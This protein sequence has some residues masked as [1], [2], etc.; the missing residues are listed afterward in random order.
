VT[1]LWFVPLA[2]CSYLL[3]AVP[4]AYL[5]VKWSRGIDI[6]TVGTGKVGA[7]NVL[8]A[9]PRWLVAPVA[10]FDVGKG[11]AAVVVTRALGFGAPAEI[12]AG[13]LAIVGHNWPVYLKFQAGGRGIFASLGVVMA[14]SWQ[15]GLIVLFLV[16]IWAPLR[17]VAFGVFTALLA[18]PFLAWFLA[19]PLDIN[20][21]LAVTWGMTAIAVMAYGRRLVARRSELSRQLPW[22]SVLANR[23][24]FDRDIGD[25]RLW[26][27][28]NGRT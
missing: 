27:A 2:V 17:Q 15:M 4:A 6:R 14:F 3:G 7:S 9:G 11:F 16:Y 28:R 19:D 13:L 25:R 10:I 26:V 12:A 5:A 20:D 8:S 21:R 22:R 23:L 1:A 18:L 24:L